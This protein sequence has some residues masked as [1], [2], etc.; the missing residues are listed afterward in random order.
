MT[1][2]DMRD[3][4]AARKAKHRKDHAHCPG[5]FPGGNRRYQRTK[6]DER[7]NRTM[8]KARSSRS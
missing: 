3:R 2:D 5:G 1:K 4:W 6:P 7:P 8:G